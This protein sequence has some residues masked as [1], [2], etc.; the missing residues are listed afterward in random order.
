[1]FIVLLIVLKIYDILNLSP[2]SADTQGNVHDPTE[3]K[4][5][6]HC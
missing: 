3:Y 5:N 1:M 6:V 2:F 4:H